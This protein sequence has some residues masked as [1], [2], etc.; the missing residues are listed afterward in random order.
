MTSAENNRFNPQAAS[1]QECINQCWTC[2]TECQKVF[3]HHCFEKDGP[4][5][6]KD[7]ARTMIDCVAICQAAAD[8]MV[9]ESPVHTA[10]CAACADVC[11]ACAYA[12]DQINTV[13]MRALA[14]TCRACAKSCRAMGGGHKEGFSP[15]LS[16][17]ADWQGQP[18]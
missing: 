16:G 13:K 11:E 18:L 4:R 1:L 12:C 6:E 2:R 10:L 3:F 14:E 8:S 17:R 7:F 5:L 9:R 15:D